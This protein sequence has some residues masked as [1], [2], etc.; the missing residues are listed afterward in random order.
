M[1]NNAMKLKLL[2]AGTALAC[3]PLLAGAQQTVTKTVTKGNGKTKSKTYT[4]PSW[5]AAHQYTGDKY[6]YF[7]DYYTYYEP[8]RGYVYWNNGKWTTSSSVPSYMS[9][10]DLNS[11]RVQII[12]DMSTRPETRYR[13]YMET[14]P[15][16]KVEVTVPMPR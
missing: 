15:A 11:A 8:D 10:V 12:E 13:T 7:P 16:Q 4:T 9:S 2:F 3:L 14:Y 5:G 6:V 1:Q